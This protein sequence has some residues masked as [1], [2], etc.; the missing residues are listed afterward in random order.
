MIS[1]Q[2]TFDPATVAWVLDKQAIRDLDGAIEAAEEVV[3]DLETTGLDEHATGRD[4]KWPCQARVALAS[5]TLP[6]A[7]SSVENPPT[8]WAVPLSHPDSPLLGNWRAVLRFL[9]QRLVQYKKPIINQNMKFDS[10]WGY[11]MTGV[12]V[13]HQIVWDTQSGAH[14]LDET[15]STKLKVRVPKVFGIERWDDF[16][17]ST[18]GAAERVPLFDLGLY[19]ARDTYWTW[20]WADRQRKMMFLHPETRDNQPEGPEDVELH[21]LGKLAT[22]VAM[23]MVATLTEIEQRGMLLDVEWTRRELASRHNEAD[24]LHRDLACRY[25]EWMVDEEPLDP[26]NASFAPTSKWFIAWTEAAVDAGDLRVTS[27]T[28]KGRPQWNKA[29]LL[30]QARTGSEV[31]Q[32]LLDLRG[33]TKKAEYL[34]SWLDHVKADG[35]IHTTYHAARVITG[36]LSSEGPNVQQITAVLKEAFPARPGKV[37]IDLDYSQIEMRVAAFVSRCPVMLQAFADGLDLHKLLALRI[38][39]LGEDGTAKAEHR[40][41]KMLTED[42]VTPVARQAGKSANFGLLF[43]M[44]PYGFQQYAETTYGLSFTIEEATLIHRAFYEQW[45]GIGPWHT[46]MISRA[47]ATGQVT[48]PIG[49]VR[50]LPEIHGGSPERQSYAERAAVNAPVQGF[51]SDIMQIAAASI[52]GTL[53][54]SERV[55]GAELIGTVHDSILIEANADDWER[56]ARECIERMLGVPTVLKRLGCDFDVPLAVEGKCGSRWGISDIGTVRG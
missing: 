32:Q 17:L 41:P 30:R 54:G 31:A 47:R 42:D 13:S 33:H 44:G 39:Q 36:R 29:V 56:V 34:A 27:F 40:V 19:A 55:V 10:R 38:L 48:S 12:D 6:D 20:R 49:R 24:T 52:A 14:L 2:D 15:S 25:P 45:T 46:K 50:R 37:I 5:F 18:P 3:V 53:P 23:P 21:R 7:G 8:T 35:R 11:A 43:T 26:Q 51:G 28:D 9:W 16:D 4:P 1:D 22:W